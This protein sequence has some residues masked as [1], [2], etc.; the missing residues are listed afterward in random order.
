[1][2]GIFKPKQPVVHKWWYVVQLD[3]EASTEEFYSAIEQDL[4]ARELQGL[5]L[6]RVEYAE[7]GLLSAQRAYLRMKRERLLFDVCS[8]PFGTSWLFSCRFSE[9]PITIRLWE[10]FALV[11]AL[12]AFWFSY[13]ELF[14]FLTGNVMFAATVIGMILAMV[15]AVPF[16]FHDMDAALM[17]I[18][19]IG[20]F[21]EVFFRKNTYYRQDTRVAYTTIVNTIVRARVLEVAK[22]RGV[23]DVQF[24]DQTPETTPS[25]METISAMFGKKPDAH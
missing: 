15:C 21:Y 8:A 11:L 13:V 24:F 18:P 6:S 1:M 9:F 23:E 12:G 5:E 22:A 20:P 3:F 14:G 25:L 19:V 2:F 7:G 10:I 17:Q 16:G 4:A